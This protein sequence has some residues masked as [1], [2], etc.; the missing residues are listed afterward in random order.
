MLTPK[1]IVKRDTPELKKGAILEV[2]GCYSNGD[3][4]YTCEDKSSCKYEDQGGVTY[5]KSVVEKQPKWFEKVSPVWLTKD[6]MKKLNKIL[7]LGKKRK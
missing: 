3:Y 7:N 4:E 5:S 1:Y 6:Q 2:D